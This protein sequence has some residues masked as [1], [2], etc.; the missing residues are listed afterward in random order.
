MPGVTVCYLCAGLQ[1]NVPV[2]STM[3]SYFG[4]ISSMAGSDDETGLGLAGR[5][6]K[7]EEG[8]EGGCQECR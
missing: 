6:S 3:T 7:G 2:P 4:A 8:G 1:Y 5:N